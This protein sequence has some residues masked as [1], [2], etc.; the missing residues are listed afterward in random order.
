MNFDK[1]HVARK[2]SISNGNQD[3]Q[4]YFTYGSEDF[5]GTSAVLR[6]PWHGGR[7][8]HDQRADRQCP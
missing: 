4:A 8:R 3:L 6:H 5:S 2:K 7:C 1:N